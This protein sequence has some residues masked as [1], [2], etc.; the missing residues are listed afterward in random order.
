MPLINVRIAPVFLLAAALSAVASAGRDTASDQLD[1]YMK[2][3]LGKKRSPSYSVAVVKD[4]KVVYAKGFGFADLENDVPAAP[5]TVYRIGSITKQFTATMIM[6]LVVEGKLKLDD[7]FSKTLPDTPKTWDKVTVRQLL[8]HTSGIKSYTEVKDLFTGEA[9]KGTSPAGILKTVEKDPMD[10]EP[11]SKWHY[12]NTGYELLGMLIE[13]LDER[14]YAASL[15]A[16]ILDPLDMKNTFFTSEK[17]LIKRRAQG[18]SLGKAGFE[19]ASYLNMDW[20]YAAGSM[21]STVLDLAKWDA[22]LY[23]DKIL[24]QSALKQMWTPTKLTDGKMERYGFGWQVGAMN[25]VPIVEHGGG[26]HG[27]TTFIRRAPSKG[28]TV[29]VLTNT[30]GPSDPSGI[31][32]TAMGIVEP[33]LKAAA[34]STIEDKNPAATAFAK[35]TLQLVLDGKLDRTKLTPDFSKALSPEMEKGAQESLGSLGKLEKFELVKEEVK[36]DVTWRT[37]RIVLGSTELKY[38]IALTA[39]GLISGL[40]VHQ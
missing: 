38:D 30:D 27:F 21:E 11:G 12:N 3:Q 25:E 26:I 6:Q 10:F 9:M 24:P 15:K 29:I 37:Y 19:H 36:D 39:K 7:P 32:R 14:T 35:S 1:T 34:V 5:E 2:E 17:A 23:G 13:K 40:G 33:T 8:N 16:R 31:A 22:A 20:P 18:Y 4:G 28:L